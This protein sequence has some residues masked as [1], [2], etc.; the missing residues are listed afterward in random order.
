MLVGFVKRADDLNSGCSGPKV[1]SNAER[2][3]KDSVLFSSDA[4]VKS[5]VTVIG[6]LYSKGWIVT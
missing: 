1:T 5:F 4:K 3:I 6:R 2:F